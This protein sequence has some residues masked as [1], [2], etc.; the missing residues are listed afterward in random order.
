M[1]VDRRVGQCWS[2]HDATVASLA[3]TLVMCWASL[4]EWFGTTDAM[5]R[6]IIIS[7]KQIEEVKSSLCVEG[8]LWLLISRCVVP[9]IEWAHSLPNVLL[10]FFLFPFPPLPSSPHLSLPPSV[11]RCVD[12]S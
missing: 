4:R 11:A 10:L 8:A 1:R 9:V 3:A 6:G 5:N 12:E 7:P 2:W